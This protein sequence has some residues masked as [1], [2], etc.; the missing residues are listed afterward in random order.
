MLVKPIYLQ[1]I[2]NTTFSD[3]KMQKI[4]DLAQDLSPSFGIIYHSVVPLV[5]QCYDSH[6]HIVLPSST[7]FHRLKIEEFHGASFVEHLSTQKKPKLLC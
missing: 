1:W 5:V 4:I 2:R 3:A 6:E 7:S